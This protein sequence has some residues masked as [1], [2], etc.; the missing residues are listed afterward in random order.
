MFP[1]QSAPRLYHRVLEVLR[2][3]IHRIRRFMRDVPG[4]GHASACQVLVQPLDRIE[5]VVRAPKPKSLPAVLTID[6]VQGLLEEWDGV[7]GLVCTLLYGSGLRRCER[8]GAVG[9]AGGFACQPIHSHLL[10]LLEGLQLRMKD[11][12][13]A[14]SEITIREGKAHKDPL[15]RLPA[16]LH[17]PLQGHLRRVR[18]QHEADLKAGLGRAPLPD[19]LLRKYPNADREWG[20]H[21]VFPASSH[22]LDRGTAI[23]HRHHLHESVLQKEVRPAACRAGIAK[24]VTPHTFRRSFAIHTIGGRLRHPDPARAAGAQGR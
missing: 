12:D 21:W 7:P 3:C 15:T 1:G 16:M 2:T 23:Q 18:E 6:E 10:R 24:R 5:K 9:G 19:A 14:R 22:H 20:W 11:L 13:F 8:I 4:V 17:E